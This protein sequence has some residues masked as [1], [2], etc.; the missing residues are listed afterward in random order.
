MLPALGAA[1]LRRELFSARSHYRHPPA[2]ALHVIYLFRPCCPDRA[3]GCGRASTDDDASDFRRFAGC[4]RGAD[5]YEREIHDMY[6]VEFADHPHFEPLLLSEEMQFHPL[7]KDFHGAPVIV[8][9][10]RRR[11]RRT[12]RATGA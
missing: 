9:R 1:E 4:I 8:E 2:P 5:W 3:Y 11:D 12:R 7:R 6:G 10:Y